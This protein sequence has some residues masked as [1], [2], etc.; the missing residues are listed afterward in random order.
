MDFFHP[1]QRFWRVIS[2]LAL[3]YSCFVIVMLNH[4]PEHGRGIL[5]YLDNRLNQDV[6]A[7]MHTYDDNCEFTPA[8]VWD[9]FDHYYLVHLGNWFLSSF[10][11]RD[12][13]ILHFKHILD[14]VIELSW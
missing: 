11:I 7:G 1:V 13:W 3:V 6:T 2:M 5:G 4:R 10:V 9:N 12:F 8:N 14:E